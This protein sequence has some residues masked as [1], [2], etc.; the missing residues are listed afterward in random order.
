MPK[1]ELFDKET[2]LENALNLFWEKGYN[3]TSIRDLEKAMNV[4]KSSIY[5][6]F[7]DKDSLFFAAL[8]HYMNFEQARISGSITGAGNA[9]SAIRSLFGCV[10]NPPQFQGKSL[11]GCLLVDSFTELARTSPA[12]KQF[13]EDAK[14]ATLELLKMLITRAQVEGDIPAS[15]KTP[16][17]A[18]YLFT[19]MQGLKV[20]GLLFKNPKELAPVVDTILKSLTCA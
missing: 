4:G 16:E 18:L 15:K 8:K 3:G 11:S 9:M 14:A 5:N 2:A 7:G 1:F 17:L 20:S 6:T 10:I 13:A 19:S 12:V